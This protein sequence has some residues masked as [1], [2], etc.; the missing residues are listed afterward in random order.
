M[1]SAADFCLKVWALVVF[2]TPVAIGLIYSSFTPLI[3]VLT[4]GLGILFSVPALIIFLLSAGYINK[5][6]LQVHVKKIIL[7][8]LGFGLIYFT[9]EFVR[10]SGDP[11]YIYGAA[12]V[13]AIFI[14][15]LKPDEK[16]VEE[17]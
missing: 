3:Y 4:I 10:L 14:F 12:L 16:P 5:Q 13:A 6:A 9:F 1:G 2:G 15:P 17:N 11:K 8:A 7:A